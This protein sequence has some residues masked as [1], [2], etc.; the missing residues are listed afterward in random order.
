MDVMARNR[1]W[2]SDFSRLGMLAGLCLLLGV[3]LI[4]SVPLIA[5]DGVFYIDQ[6]RRV[7]RDPLAVA[8]RHPPGYPFLLWV[9]HVVTSAFVTHD[10][11]VLWARSGQGITLLCR[12]LALVP[13]YFLGKRLV[14]PRD[15]FRALLILVVLPYP[16]YYGS[17][18]L[19]EWPY[20]LFLSLGFWMLYRGL[21]EG[22]RWPFA[23]AGLAAGLGYLI[24]PECAQLLVYGLLGLA[25]LARRSLRR[26]HPAPAPG[27]SGARAADESTTGWA[28]NVREGGAGVLASGP[29]GSR[30]ALARWGAGLLLAGF[31]V[32]AVPCIRAMGTIVPQQLTSSATNAPPVILRAGSRPAG[33]DPLEF[34]VR[35]GE[36]LEVPLEA[37]DPED[38]PLTFT[39]VGI[40]ADS[41]PVYQFRSAATGAPLWTCSEDEKSTLLTRYCPAVWQ[42][43]GIVCYA[44]ARPDP[45]AGLQPVHRFWS[46]ARQRHFYT[47]SA[48]EKRA[49]LDAAA[50]GEWQY[51]GVAFYAYAESSHPPDAVP[52]YRSGKEWGIADFGFR[53]AD[54]TRSANPQSAII[55]PQSGQVAWYVPGVGE[56]PAGVTIENQVL[57]WRP[58]P[59]QQGQYEI[60]IVVSDGQL[61]TCQLVKVRVQ[62]VAAGSQVNRPTSS[63]ETRRSSVDSGARQG[64]NPKF[65]YRNPKQAR[66]SQTRNSNQEP[67]G[68]GGSV[69]QIPG[70]LRISA[71]GRQYAGLAR[72]PAAV[73]QLFD[74]I[75][76]GL[77]VVFLVP[78][79]LGL[80][81]RLRYQAGRVE[82]VLVPALFL[83]NLAAMLA[84]SVWIAPGTDRRYCLGLLVLTIFYV[85][86]GLQ[87]MAGWLR[88][89]A[90]WGLRIADWRRK[91][92]QQESPQSSIRNPQY[93]L[94]AIGIGTCVFRL[95]MAPKVDKGS[96]LAMARWLHENTASDAVVAV[97]DIRIGFY[98]E[99][100]ALFY[101]RQFDPRRADY[102][103]QV[104]EQDPPAVPPDWRRE[105]A[106]P[107]NRGKGG[108]VVV[109]YRIVR[110]PH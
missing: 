67:T 37:F 5:N 10:S 92:A 74:G 57:R 87:L 42:Y 103:V 53:I 1:W 80:Y 52:V 58:R 63:A 60:N 59:D 6:A 81:Y 20:V 9:A 83:V 54:S 12:V 96:Y 28:R 61:Q 91:T 11:A 97:P 66:M 8:R 21:Q 71:P 55:D 64:G 16:A 18:V 100:P 76:E 108:K 79:L 7:I 69:V 86:A 35:P 32:P 27:A 104:E 47:A 84:R 15:S 62:A 48:A 29:S 78:W 88:E 39:L 22:T 102:A 105:Y 107:F 33:N 72:L 34:A 23:V 26:G 13:L 95:G 70:S 101:K 38:Q 30:Q 43:D 41:R 36:L 31:A 50:P 75:A 68:P 19:R 85:P 46:V 73:D 17:N 44:Y 4:V 45:P 25:V 24:R 94:L 49:A 3:F 99:R 51:E 109:A 14:G 40:P 65:E 110:D 106:V 2:Q 89:I 82:R 90:D 93:F 77:M 56:P 98:A